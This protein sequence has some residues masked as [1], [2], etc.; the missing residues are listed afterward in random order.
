M[1]RQRAT[2]LTFAPMV[3]SETMR[4]LLHYHGIAFDEADHLFGWVSL[5]T[6]RHGGNGLVP[7]VY[8]PAFT[9]TG[10]YPLAE[11]L[12]A[13]LGEAARLIPRTAPLS[14]TVAADWASFNA[15]MGTDTAVFSYYHLLP[16]RALMTPIFAAP[17]PSSEARLTPTVYPLLRLVFRL[18]LDLTAA[19]AE[20][21][22]NSIR[23]HFDATDRRLAD[24]RRYLCGDRITLGDIA[25]A[26]AIAPLLQPPGYGARMPP[27][28]AMP[29]PVRAL[30]AEL[31]EHPT[32]DYVDRL[33]CDRFGA[34]LI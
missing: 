27:V 18:A 12:D 9:I 30:I 13:A 16:E 28:D 10:P 17:V 19:R 1:K 2:L 31:R 21:A 6:L 25:V 15:G 8:G 22:A 20:Q 7:L 33:Y 24:G 23:A 32:A 5:L 26:A 14:A 4:L 34:T 29:A 3:D 11:R